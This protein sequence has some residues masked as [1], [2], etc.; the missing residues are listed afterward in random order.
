MEFVH[1][2][3]VDEVPYAMCPFQG[4]LLVGVGRYLRLYDL[5]KKKLLR[6]CENK[7]SRSP[8]FES[9]IKKKKK[10]HF[11]FKYFNGLL[12]WQSRVDPA[13]KCEV[14]CV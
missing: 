9:H 7:V 2:T 14:L 11:N 4:A 3:S 1:K 5:G 6:K 10:T 13:P 12:F 8:G